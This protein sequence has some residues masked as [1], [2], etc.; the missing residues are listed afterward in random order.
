MITVVKEQHLSAGN[1]AKIQESEQNL[2][3]TNDYD[4]LEPTRKRRKLSESCF[5]EVKTKKGQDIYINIIDIPLGKKVAKISP[6]KVEGDKPV[7]QIIQE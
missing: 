7:R 6:F 3:N 1:L 4:S 5:K 2:L